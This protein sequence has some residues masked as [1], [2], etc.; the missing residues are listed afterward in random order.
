MWR[1]FFEKEVETGGRM[2]NGIVSVILLQFSVWIYNILSLLQS[3]KWGELQEMLWFWITNGKRKELAMNAILIYSHNDKEFKLWVKGY[4]YSRWWIFRFKTRRARKRKRD[5]E[6]EGGGWERARARDGKW[7]RKRE[8]WHSQMFLSATEKQFQSDSVSNV[9]KR[10][11]FLLF[12][13]NPYTHTHKPFQNR[14]K[15]EIG[16]KSIATMTV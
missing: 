9:C 7:E 5:I 10:S 12:M 1:S 8:M 15:E 14:E 4:S 3:E 2:L 16:A 11:V 13:N 6:R